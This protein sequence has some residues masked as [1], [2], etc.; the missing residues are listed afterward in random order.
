MVAGVPARY[1]RYPHLHGD[2]LVFCAA[3]DLWLAP[4][5]GGRGWRLTSDQVPVRGPRF[6]PDGRHVA[7]ASS[8]DGQFEVLVLAL[9]GGEPERLTYWGSATTRV[10]GWTADGRVLAA[11]SAGEANLRQVFAKA[12][13]LDGRV[14]RLPYG[15]VSG[16]A[17]RPGGAAA[18]ASYCTRDSSMWKR[19]RGGTASRLWVR[20]RAGSGWRRLLPDLDA[21]LASPTWVGD[22]LAFVS[23]H[24]AGLSDAPDGQANLWSVTADGAGLT[25]HTDHGPGDGYVRDP[26]GDGSRLV[27]HTRGTLYRMDSLDRPPVRVEI[28][29]GG[30]AP[31]RRRRPLRPTEDLA[32]LRPDHTGDGS[33]VEWRGKAFF[34]THREGPARALLAHS[35]GRAREPHPLGRSGRVVLISDAGAEDRLEVH[36]LDGSTEPR[37]LAAGELGR[38][39]SLRPDPAG[40]RVAVV[41]HDGRISVVE[42]DRGRVIPVG[43]SPEGEATG[44][45]FSPDGRYLVW[46]QPVGQHRRLVLADL[47]ARR[48]EGTPVT[49]GRFSDFSPSFTDDGLHLVLLSARTFDPS[50]DAHVFNVG[51]A[52][53]V[54]PYLIPLAAT[55]PAPFG[56]SVEGWRVGS[57][58]PAEQPEPERGDAGAPPVPPAS[59]DVDLEGF[60]DRIVP[61]PVP[62]GAYRELRAAHGAVL[63]VH[64]APGRG[65]LGAAHAG[66]QGDPPGDA[67]EVYGFAGRK[68]E[69]LLD[70]VDA[71]EVSGDGRRIV[72]RHKETVTTG[73]ADSRVKD[74]DPTRFEIDLTRLR[75]EL[76][77]VAEWRQMFDENA[78]LMRDHYWRADLDGV[79]WA[80]VVDRYRPLVDRLGSPDDLLDLLA[81]TVGEL[82]TSHAYVTAK[83][84]PGEAAGR[85]GLLGAD[86]APAGDGWRIEAI[87]PGESSDPQARSPLRA[88]GV[89]ARVGDLIVAVDGQPVDPAYGPAARLVGAADQPVELTLRSGDRRQPDRRVA[90]LPLADEEALR[91]H[92]WVASRK[93]Y[94][95]EAGPGRI[96]YLHIPDM[97]S[98]GWSQLHREIELATRAEGLVVDVRYNRGG[99]LSQLVIERLARRVVGW[100]LA[101]HIA[102]P[103]E[104]PM[105]APRGPVVFVANE[106]TGSDGDIVNAAAQALGLGPVVGM[107]T[108]GGVVGI[109]G[110]YEL[111]DGTRVTQP[112]YA[113][114]LRG[115]GWGVENHGVDPDIEVVLTPADWHGPADPQLDRAVA[116]ALRR[117]TET[118]AATPPPLPPPRVRRG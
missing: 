112:R 15:P 116:E 59:P 26:A 75:F 64:E 63:W 77:P 94:V 17:V 81:E 99:H 55:E 14:E 98:L 44:L 103:V 72:V 66:V 42:L 87:L 37:I 88:A 76:D 107:R 102:T 53:A 56:P 104:Y 78:R 70:A 118:P 35:G 62:A 33:V 20:E 27:Y 105:Q 40:D 100:D 21:S 73:P 18:V 67:L 12:I 96:G 79:D 23:D 5:A 8:R 25:R 45:A 39:L 7:W 49:S 109:D 89:G 3:D 82:N 13:G 38:V 1:L 65:E 108:W 50:Y 51:F 57:G 83:E 117:L 106:Y 28:E 9:D 113:F 91:Y 71:Y 97:M 80:A 32:T 68:L 95:R 110:R 10:L 16:V 52:F 29:L 69:V 43:T 60:E 41:S 4:V 90:V 54:R 2:L 86:L 48:P 31:A 19:Y 61:F 24:E 85:L 34:L 46:S 101:R 36:A 30:P 47:R 92:A 6:S 74:D 58:K 93:D 114:W 11:S 22:R 115:Y 84:Q 111:V